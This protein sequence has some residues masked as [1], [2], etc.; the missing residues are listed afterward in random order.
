MGFARPPVLSLMGFF[1]MPHIF[2]DAETSLQKKLLDH[3]L[4]SHSAAQHDPATF[5]RYEK[6]SVQGIPEHFNLHARNQPHGSQSALE[7]M[8]GIHGNEPNPPARLHNC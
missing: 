6:W 8:S 2:R 1:G 7:S 5:Y 4:L 3:D